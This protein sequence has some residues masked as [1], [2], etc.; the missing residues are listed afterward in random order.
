LWSQR[1]LSSTLFN[2]SVTSEDACYDPT[3]AWQPAPHRCLPRELVAPGSSPMTIRSGLWRDHLPIWGRSSWQLCQTRDRS[4]E[5]ST[6]PWLP[7]RLSRQQQ[8][9][10]IMRPRYRFDGEPS[11]TKRLLGGPL[12]PPALPARSQRHVRPARRSDGP[13]PSLELPVDFRR[14][15]D[16]G[17][18]DMVS[19]RRL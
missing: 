9:V 4:P 15:L 5:V 2:E 3:M 8:E 14:M 11:L 17:L 13:R 16:D 6:R 19:K 12:P 10:S 7:G 18:S 1:K